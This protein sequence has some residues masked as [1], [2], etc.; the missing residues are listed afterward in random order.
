[1]KMIKKLIRM[2][3][4]LCQSKKSY[5]ATLA[6][7]RTVHQDDVICTSSLASSGLAQAVWPSCHRNSR[8]RR[9]GWGCLNSH[10]WN[11]GRHVDRLVDR[12]TT[13]GYMVYSWNSTWVYSFQPLNYLTSICVFKKSL[14][15]LHQKQTKPHFSF[16]C[17]FI[18]PHS[19]F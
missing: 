2:S 12:Q 15:M 5:P 19:M 9:N 3:S 14:N 13:L 6:T 16:V 17:P 1:M 4:A 7:A 18:N 11:R 10:R 8:V